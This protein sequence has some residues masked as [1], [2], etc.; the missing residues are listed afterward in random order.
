MAA[1][2]E[3]AA[4]LAPARVRVLLIVVAVIETVAAFNGL[5][6]LFG[7]LSEVPGTGPAG[8][9]ILATIVLRPVFAIA[10]LTFAVRRRLPRA[11]L[12]LAVVVLLS[13][14]SLLPSVIIHGL[15]LSPGFPGLLIVANVVLF[16]L[17]ALAALALAWRDRRL[18]L[19][20]I[21]AS[22]PTLVW[23]V[24]FIVFAVAIAIYGF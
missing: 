2:A 21:L 14:L 6:V 17:L 18:A 19:A 11:V 9:T 4:P 23:I 24:G 12:A 5:P 22:L 10:A 7:D 20:A 15:E 16:P 3:A 13:W 1:T 8:W